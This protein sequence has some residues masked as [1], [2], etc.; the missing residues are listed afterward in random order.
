MRSCVRGTDVAIVAKADLQDLWV[1][2]PPLETQDCIVALD[3][4]F[5]QEK[6]Q[7]AA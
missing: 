1:H 5:V 4:L 6:K 3:D 7:I 2:L